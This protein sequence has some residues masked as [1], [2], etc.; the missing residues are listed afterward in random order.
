MSDALVK[1]E[2]LSGFQ[3]FPVSGL[4]GSSILLSI[5]EA[6]KFLGITVWQIRGLI[7]DRSL[8]VVTIGRKF[9]LR[10]AALVRFAESAEK[11]L[12]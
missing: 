1:H 12:R 6:G 8:P 11:F 3:G 9:Y 4:K 2:G 5:P 10:R 7:A